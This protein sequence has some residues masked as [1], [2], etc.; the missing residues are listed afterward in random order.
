ML[1]PCS[2]ALLD[3]KEGECPLVDAADRLFSAAAA[4]DDMLGVFAALSCL[5]QQDDTSFKLQLYLL[6]HHRVLSSSGTC[7]SDTV[8]VPCYL[9]FNSVSSE[10]KL[11][12][13]N[14]TD[15]SCQRSHGGLESRDCCPRLNTSL[16]CGQ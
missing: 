11:H 3:T 12:S 6:L 10:C 13:A 5:T 2:P 15:N 8:T 14:Q 4:G 9:L 1:S 7:G 16:R